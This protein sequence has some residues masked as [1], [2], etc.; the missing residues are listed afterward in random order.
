MMRQ[1][2]AEASIIAAIRANP[3]RF[4]VSLNKML[5]LQREGVSTRILNAVAIKEMRRRKGLSGSGGTNADELSPQP[6]P[7]KGAL[8]TPGAQQTLLGTQAN[9]PSGDGSKSALVPTVQRPAATEGT[10]QGTTA[11]SPTAV[12]RNGSLGDA[13]VQVSASGMPTAQTGTLNGGSGKT[14]VAANRAAVTAPA[15]MPKTSPGQIG[16]SQTMSAQGNASSS[17]AITQPARTASLAPQAAIASSTPRTTNLTAIEG[18]PSQVNLQVAAECAKDPSRRILGV[19]DGSVAVKTFKIGHAY[20]IV[21]CSFGTQLPT[22]AVYMIGGGGG[23]FGGGI[24]LFF[25]IQSWNDNFIV[26]ST[27]PSETA[28][29]TQTMNYYHEPYAGPVPLTVYIS[30]GQGASLSGCGISVN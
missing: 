19:F 10:K 2:Q 24:V 29:L 28:D 30:Q 20:T 13:S 11:M 14:A 8:M 15:M 7:P 12:E 22:G 25:Q 23:W 5:A 1:G 21:G 18:M 3:A 6:Y 16:T 4:D 27:D 9:S 17:T 26:F